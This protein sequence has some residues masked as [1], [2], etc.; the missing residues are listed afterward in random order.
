MN[1]FR[2]SRGPMGPEAWARGRVVAIL[3]LEKAER[4]RAAYCGATFETRLDV[5][6]KPHRVIYRLSRDR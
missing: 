5:E 2:L 3:L 6:G 4:V 1:G